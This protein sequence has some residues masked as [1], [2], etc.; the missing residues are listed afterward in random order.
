MPTIKYVLEQNARSVVLVSHLGKAQGRRNEQLTL[1]PV[2]DEL[3]RLLG[4]KVIFVQDCVGAEA[5]KACAHPEPGSV[6]LM[7]NLRFHPEEDGF[8]VK[9]DGERVSHT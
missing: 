5:A 6:F 7:E 8:G 3:E 9:E 1:K 4:S 2:A